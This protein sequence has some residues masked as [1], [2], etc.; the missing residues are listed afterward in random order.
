M[1]FWRP[2]QL[3]RNVSFIELYTLSLTQI[4][5]WYTVESEH[6]NVKIF[7]NV[8]LQIFQLKGGH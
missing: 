6:S 3:T 2:V 8:L 7:I 1:L 5:N 4:V